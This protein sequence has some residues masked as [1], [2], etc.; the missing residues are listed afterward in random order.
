MSSLHRRLRLNELGRSRQPVSLEA[1]A[2]DRRDVAKELGLIALISLRAELTVG[3]W[4]DGA[5]VNGRFEAE[6]TQEC[7]VTLDPFDSPVSGD[8]QVR[9]VPAGSPYA[10][11][12]AGEIELDPE[13]E[14]PPD[15]L[16]GSEIDLGDVVIEQLALSLDPFPRK[17]G[18]EFEPP[19]ADPVESPFAVLKSLKSKHEGS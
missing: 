4:L 14:D 9:L 15:V 1:D 13:A 17:P 18:A 10:P 2:D 3:P 11:A 6:V 7:G 19:S 5:E 16:S 8:I 12:E